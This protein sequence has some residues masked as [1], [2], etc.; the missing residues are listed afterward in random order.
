MTGDKRHGIKGIN[1]DFA[2]TS[3]VINTDKMADLPLLL[4]FRQCSSEDVIRH[5][6]NKSSL[7]EA[8]CHCVA[9]C[10]WFDPIL[11]Q[12]FFSTRNTLN[13]PSCILLKFCFKMCKTAFME[14]GLWSEW[15]WGKQSV[16][17]IRLLII[18]PLS[19]SDLFQALRHTC[20]V[21]M[22]SMEA[23]PSDLDDLKDQR[24]V[25]MSKPYGSLFPFWWHKNAWPNWSRHNLFPFRYFI[26]LWRRPCW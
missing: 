15:S 22:I 20:T 14:A 1:K 18:R 23:S 12:T 4:Y 6:I 25:K 17:S 2:T 8:R 3:C 7:T 9:G 13:L 26:T 21:S 5:R 11:K 24:K 16:T 19:R 10:G